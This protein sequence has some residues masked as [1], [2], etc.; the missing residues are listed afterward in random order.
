MNLP[1]LHSSTVCVIGLGYVGFPLAFELS[2][3]IKLTDNKTTR[4]KVIGFDINEERINQ[5]KQ[6]HD[7]TNEIDLEKENVSSLLEFTSDEEEINKADIFKKYYITNNNYLTVNNNNEKVIV[8]N[9]EN[10][11]SYVTNLV[12]NDNKATI[13]ISGNFDVKLLQKRLIVEYQDGNIHVINIGNVNTFD[14]DG[15]TFVYQYKLILVADINFPDNEPV[16]IKITEARET[17][18]NNILNFKIKVLKN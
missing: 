12:F 5:L 13:N 4:R 17:F 10:T 8:D 16:T 6:G 9:L 15:N 18:N 14:I 1:D 2:K 11:G 3:P 7:I